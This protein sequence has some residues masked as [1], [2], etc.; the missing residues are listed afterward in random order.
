MNVHRDLRR[1]VTLGLVYLV[2][3]VMLLIGLFAAVVPWMIVAWVLFVVLPVCV[4]EK[5]GSRG[6][7]RRTMEMTNGSRLRLA[8]LTI[9]IMIAYGVEGGYETFAFHLFGDR[10]GL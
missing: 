6:T 2:I 3:D 4:S 1:F 5:R 7:L 10:A 9:V 8:G